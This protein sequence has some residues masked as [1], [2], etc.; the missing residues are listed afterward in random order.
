MNPVTDSQLT[1]IESLILRRGGDPKQL[2]GIEVNGRHYERLA[3]LTRED[4]SA[5]IDNLLE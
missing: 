1:F 2:R 5:V 4:A 3:D